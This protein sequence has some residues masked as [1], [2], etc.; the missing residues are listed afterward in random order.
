MILMK[1]RFPV[2]LMIFAVCLLGLSCKSF[3]RLIDK[4]GNVF[5]VEIQTDEPNSAAIIERAI[6]IVQNK[7]NHVG[8]DGEVTKSSEKDNQIVLKIYGSQDWTRLKK[9]LFASNRLQLKAVASPPSPSPAKAYPTR[10]DAAEFVGEKEE[11]LPFNNRGGEAESF[12]IVER[13]DIINGEDILDAK[14]V[15]RTDSPEDYQISFSVKPEG[16]KKLGDW[17]AQNISNYIA[18]VLDDE[19][20]SVSDVKS[21]ITDSGEISGRFTEQTAEDI[22]LSLKSGYLPAKMMVI[23]EEPFGK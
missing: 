7:I 4:S 10:A 9:F 14:A 15:N 5:V 17:T 16:A 20:Q 19:V 21:Q 12:V 22:A 8:V 1:P 3:S 2:L 23:R 18:I 13:E 11:I 6:K